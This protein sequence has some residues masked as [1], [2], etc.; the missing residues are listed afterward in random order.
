MRFSGPHTRREV[1]DR[2]IVP[3]INVV[4]LLLIFFLMSATLAP[5][6]PFGIT[7]PVSEGAER[8]PLP[9]TL[10]I[11]SEGALSYSGAQ[12]AAIWSLLEDHE[13]PLHLR[14]DA[15]FPAADLAAVIPR[16]GDAGISEIRLVTV[17]P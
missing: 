15:A 6:D 8:D 14:V 4:F 11:S 9:L 1:Q 3:M 7:P 16:I 13:G 2:A 12:G 17:R 10:H 5:P